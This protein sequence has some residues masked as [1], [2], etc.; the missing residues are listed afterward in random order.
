M[1]ACSATSQIPWTPNCGV[2]QTQKSP[3]IRTGPTITQSGG[4][5]NAGSKVCK[6]CLTFWIFVIVGVVAILFLSD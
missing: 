6:H 3:G 1:S 5:S 2:T 4:A